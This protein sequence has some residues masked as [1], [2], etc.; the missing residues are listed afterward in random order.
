MDVGM[1]GVDGIE[2][3]RR[4]MATSPTAVVMLT[5]FSDPEV[6][7]EAL[8]AGAAG[9]LVKPILQ[10]QLGPTLALAVAQSGAVGGPGG[11]EAA[12]AASRERRLL[13]DA[14]REASDAR[15]R[16]RKLQDELRHEREL[17]RVLVGSFL[18][19]PPEIPGLEIARCFEAATELAL[20]GGDFVDFLLLPDGRLSIAIGDLCG[21]GLESIPHAAR[22]K[23]MLRG[24][25]LE[26][27]KP[28]EVVGR[29]NH[30]AVHQLEERCPFL[31]LFYGILSLDR[32]TLDYCNGGH[33]PPILLDSAA[34]RPTYLEPTG[35]LVGVVP[36]MEYAQASVP[37]PPGAVLA[38][39]TDGVT[40]ARSGTALLGQAGVEAVL[41]EQRLQP[42]AA[43]AEAIRDRALAHAGGRLTD[44]LSALVLRRPPA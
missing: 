18:T 43:I 23:F 8:D 14:E 34:A 27:P 19:E 42:A 15:A 33:P 30:A 3:T 37:L 5:A 28:A 1:P 44:D 12:R 20:V 25:A 9:Y 10:E 36:E 22:T 4:I 17:A 24:Y 26:D 16:A 6:V 11:G 7:Q 35:G 31:S 21:H 13:R 38:L 29:L 2:A 41:R 40:E 39:F 32:W